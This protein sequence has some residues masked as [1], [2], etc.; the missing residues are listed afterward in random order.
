MS[1]DP[2]ISPTTQKIIKISLAEKKA[3]AWVILATLIWGSQYI[4]IK[5]GASTIPPYTFQAI[6]YSFAF[7]G[8]LPFW[9]RLRKLNRI[10][11]EAISI[12]ALALFLITMFITVGLTQTTSNKGAFLASLYV[13]ATPFVARW[14]IKSK[15]SKRQI[16]AV[17]IATIGMGIMIFGNAGTLDEELTPNVGDL[18]VIIGSMVNA[19]QIVLLEK[20]ANKVDITLFVLGQMLV[21]S[22]TLFITAGII[23]EWNSFSIADITSNIWWIM[24]YLGIIGATLTLM[25][26]TTAQKIIDSTRAALLY[27]L[28]PVFAIFFGIFVG[29]EILTIAFIIGAAIIMCAILLSSINA[30]GKKDGKSEETKALKTNS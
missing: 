3:I 5:M 26:Q 15:I 16:I 27:S 19:V 10:T 14:M 28:E 1:S 24:A 2:N 23:G 6:R 30:S 25:I 4:L 7:L 9:G 29:G 12:N 22:I 21:L 17:I 18:L 8:F 13:I 11:I 20:Y